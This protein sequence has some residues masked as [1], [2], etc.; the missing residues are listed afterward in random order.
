MALSFQFYEKA[1]LLYGNGC[2]SQIG[3]LAKDYI[4]G[5]KALIVVDPGMKT[6][7]VVD[8]IV[9][10]LEKSGIKH[11][12]FDESEPNP[13][14]A[15]SEKAYKLFKKEGCDVVIGAGGGSNM[16]CAKGVNILRF[17]PGPLLQY[18]NF[19]KPFEVGTGLIMVPTTS[20]TGSEMSDGAILSDEHHVKLNFIASECFAEYA[21]LD[22]E[23]LAGMPPKLTA[24]TG[25]DALAHAI[26]GWTGT[27]TNYFM[28]FFDE[29]IVRDVVKYLPRAVSNGKEDLVARGKM[30]VASN[31][32]GFSLVYAH[33]NAGHSI[34]QTIGAY[35]DIPHGT[36]CAYALPWVV[37]FNAIA[38]PELTKDV[39]RCFGVTFTGNEAPEDIGH[40]VREAIIKF[41][42]V[43]CR[44]PSIKTYRYDES[45]FD[46]IAQVSAEEF[47]Q[48]FNPRK[49]TKAD[50]L[51]VLRNM[52][53]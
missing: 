32:A 13:P 38:V 27:L 26:E 43:D 6:T 24:S 1:K 53:A 12:V 52:Y 39:G 16:D 8:K 34:G 41:R 50:C 47:F 44:L 30:A 35:F 11:V 33:V 5:T 42:D 7:G 19:Q 48:M 36:A 9:A 4:H 46:E 18:A 40:M 45:K 20:G 31:V 51:A 25:L 37:E 10:G 22:P 28:E 3:E 23:L 2:I 29:K 17:N 14:I 49:M 15:A 21:V